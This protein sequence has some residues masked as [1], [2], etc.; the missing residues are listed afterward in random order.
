MPR[1]R[2]IKPETF[3]DEKLARVSRESRYL[4]VGLW[5]CSDDYGVT[6]GHP[7]WLKSQLFPYD[8]DL[9]MTTFEKWLSDLE[10]HKFIISFDRDG[11]KFY[12]IPH[13]REHQRVDHPSKL[14][15]PAPPESIINIDSRE[16]RECSREFR[17]ETET[18]TD[19]LKTLAH[20]GNGFKESFEKFWT[21]Y[22]KKKSKGQAEK[23]WYKIKPDEQLLA[24]ILATIE[25]AKTSEEW[26]KDNGK[27]I[28][29]PATWL[30][31]KG[32]EDEFK[33]KIEQSDPYDGLERV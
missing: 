25:R 24:R 26:T 22:P 33:I 6:K 16:F 3:S 11:E 12:Y 32:W 1:T 17:D 21:A 14:R 2:S 10:K 30:N 23:T 15:N 4:F 13:F 19:T 20:S 29:H 28:P 8:H 7:A 9:K 31:A 27:Y 18:E 5:T